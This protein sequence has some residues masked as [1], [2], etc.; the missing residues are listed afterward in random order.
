MYPRMTDPLLR[1]MERLLMA[2]RYLYYVE[3][4]P[5]LR[6]SEYDSID[7]VFLQLVPMGGEL[8]SPLH[9]PG[10]ELRS[11]YTTDEIELAKRLE[12]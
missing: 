7:R 9:H 8:E 10:S 4:S 6:D 11:S 5:T 12:G 1:W 2:H 3:C